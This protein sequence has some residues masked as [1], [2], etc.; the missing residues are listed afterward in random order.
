ME[1]RHVG[2]VSL[3]RASALKLYPFYVF[4]VVVDQSEQQLY[5]AASF[6]PFSLQE[7]SPPSLTPSP[8]L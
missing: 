4:L 2:S 1:I 7:T 5:V 8:S 3:N 6:S